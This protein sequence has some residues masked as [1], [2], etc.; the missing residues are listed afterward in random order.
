ML[1]VLGSI[2][3]GAATPTE[4]AAIGAVGAIFL[5]SY[6]LKGNTALS[7]ATLL[8]IGGLLLLAQGKGL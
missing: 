2:L 5:A 7:L 8:A 6:K 4:A 1:G 3:S